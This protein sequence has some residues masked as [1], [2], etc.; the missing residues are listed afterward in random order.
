[1]FINT[2]WTHSA[3]T[4]IRPVIWDLESLLTDILSIHVLWAHQVLNF[5]HINN[6]ASVKAVETLFRCKNF[7]LFSKFVLF[8]PTISQKSKCS[9]FCLLKICG[10]FG[11]GRGVPLFS[12][13]LFSSLL[14]YFATFLVASVGFEPKVIMGLNLTL[15]TRNVAK[16]KY[17]VL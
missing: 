17:M 13:F 3:H 8:M 11:M 15:D 2:D 10:Y 4:I 14:F 5:C 9:R 16:I 6:I 7:L 12:D 1:M